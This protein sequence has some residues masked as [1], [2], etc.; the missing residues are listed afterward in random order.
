MRAFIINFTLFLF[1]LSLASC[2]Q[3][4]RS[5]AEDDFVSKGLQRAAAQCERMALQLSDSTGKLP[6]TYMNGKLVLSGTRWW[7]SGFFPGTLWYLYEYSK[8]ENLKQYATAYTER[9]RNEMYTTSHHDV[10]FMI[11]CS[12]GNGYRLTGNEDYA[13]VID[14]ACQ[15]LCTRY[16]ERVGAIRSWDSN[17]DRWKYPVIIDNM[18]N[19]EM[20][21]WG[22]SH[23]NRKD[24]SDIAISHADK[25]MKEHYRNDYSCYHV[26]S[27]NPE[28]GEAEKKQTAQGAADSSAW[29][30]GQAWG[31]YGY[32]MMYRFT[33][34]ERYLTM[35]E[36]IADFLLSH[37]N[38]PADKIPYWDFN[39]PNIPNEERDASA[40]CIMASALIELSGYVDG[41]KKQTYLSV[42]EQQLRTLC[43][44]EY[45]APEGENGNFILRHSVGAKPQ[46]AN[47]P[48]FGEVDVP[49]TYADYYFVE[50]LVR[51]SKLSE[52]KSLGK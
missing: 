3:K 36:H 52:E 16:N 49:L 7:C 37:P 20:L 19:L 2:G 46:R 15:S 25:T 31:L 22:A 48:Y 12:Y 33:H 43:S 1:C 26:V 39:A 6:R 10:G 41:D 8:N 18:M 5:S 47:A 9:L 32:T 13:T 51:W 50:A 30:R 35:A 28:T 40:A 11:F 45:L 38:M 4:Q 14:T 17:K 44:D 24:W 23:F 42:A 34:E 27:Y 21:L 29:A